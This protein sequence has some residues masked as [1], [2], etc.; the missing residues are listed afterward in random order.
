M[1]TFFISVLL[2]S[3]V[4]FGGRVFA[5]VKIGY[6]DLQRALTQVS[7][8]KAAKEKLEKKVKVKQAEF[9]KMQEEAKKLKDELETQGAMMK[10]DLKRQKIQ[11]Y[12]KKLMEL[13]DY[14]LGNQKELAEEEAKLTR[15]ILERFEKILK[16]I[17]KEEGYTII[18]EKSAVVFAS[19]SVDLTDR[20]I[21]DFNAGGGK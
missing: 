3:L 16:K 14:Y 6:V 8:G 21:K 18:V 13:Q 17:G 12:Q 9:D 10:E 11:E 19:P 15:P 5:D 7:E 1:K 20:L 2:S 4:V